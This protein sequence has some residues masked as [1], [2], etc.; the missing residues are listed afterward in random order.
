M[1]SGKEW[2]SYLL[3]WNFLGDKSLSNG[4]VGGYLRKGKSRENWDLKSYPRGL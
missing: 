4:D 2:G 1:R 3:T